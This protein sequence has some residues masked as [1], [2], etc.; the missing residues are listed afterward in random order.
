MTDILLAK[1]TLLKGFLDASVGEAHVVRD[2]LLSIFDVSACDVPKVPS[3]FEYLPPQGYKPLV[4]LL[5]NKYQAPVVICNGAKNALGA[6]FYALKQMGKN[7]VYLPSPH[8]ALIPPLM[9]M[10]GLGY[11]HEENDTDSC[12]CVAPNNPDGS[13]VDL[14]KLSSTAKRDGKPFIHDSVYF[15]HIYLPKSYQL[16]QYGDVQIYSSSKSLG[17]SSLRI[18]WATIS[19]PELY[20]LVLQYMEHMT[21]GASIVSQLFLYNLLNTMQGYPTLTEKFETLAALTL[22]ENKLLIKQV[23]PEIL[24][25]PSN[26]EDIPGMFLFCKIKDYSVLERAK[27]NAIDGKYFGAPG[28]VRINLALNSVTIQEIV[29]RLNHCKDF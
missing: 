23:D 1:P 5:E 29:N 12:L 27:I 7:N 11:S 18:G 17:L 2:A 26:M 10:H 19:N 21:V 13:M 15:N 6:I 4:Q 22:R 16:K 14:E 3:L 28:Y 8:W 24:E 25:V 20:K 9:E